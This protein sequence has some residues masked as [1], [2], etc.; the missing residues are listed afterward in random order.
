[1]EQINELCWIELLVLNSFTWDYL[2]VCKQ[3]N[4]NSFENKTTHK[5][6]TYKLYMHKQG[7]SFFVSWHINL[8]RL[9]NSKA[10]L[11]EEQ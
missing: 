3:I 11:V 1:M 6:F 9:L 10:I 5:L 7:F 8:C 4:S 2:T